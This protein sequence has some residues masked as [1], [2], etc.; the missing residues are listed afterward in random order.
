[1]GADRTGDKKMT[2]FSHVVVRKEPENEKRGTLIHVF[3]NKEAAKHWIEQQPN[4]DEFCV[5]SADMNKWKGWMG[6]R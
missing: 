1:M 5:A 2:S 6:T 3:A 4:P